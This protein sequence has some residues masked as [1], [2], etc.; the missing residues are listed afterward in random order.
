MPKGKPR[1]AANPSSW[2]ELLNADKCTY[3]NQI[4]RDKHKYLIIFMAFV[5]RDKLPL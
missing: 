3:I 5:K 1:Q 2:F 4:C